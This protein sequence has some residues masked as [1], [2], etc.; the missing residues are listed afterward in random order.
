MIKY[1]RIATNIC[2]FFVL[3][4]F[5]SKISLSF[6]ALVPYQ[7]SFL[8]FQHGMHPYTNLFIHACLSPIVL[9]YLIKFKSK[10]FL[11]TEYKI[12][13][14]VLIF[15][16]TFQTFFQIAF[17]NTDQSPFYQLSG[18]FMAIGLIGIY[19][20]FIPLFLEKKIFINLIR[21]ASL[22]IIIISFLLLFF[23]FQT[24]KGGRFTGVFKHIP[25]MVSVSVL[26]YIFYFPNLIKMDKK[27]I[28][29]LILFILLSLTI[30]LTATKTSF[31]AMILTI[32]LGIFIFPIT[33]KNQFLFKSAFFLSI[34]FLIIFLHE[35]IT[36]TILDVSTG[37]TELG[38]RK[39]QNGV[40]SRVEE[41]ERGYDLFQRSP[42]FGLGLLYK[43]FKN[44]HDDVEVD[45]YNSFKDPHNIF[46][47][48]A[49]IGGIPLL[50][51]AVYAVIAMIL[52]SFKGLR[53]DC[54]HTRL[55]ALYLI[56]H[57]P[58]LIIYHAHF[59]L[60][61]IADRFYWLIFGYLGV[62]KKIS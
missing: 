58:I 17:V 26:A 62:S 60:G 24:F 40:Q 1:N 53:S 61:G 13:I 9:F 23:G 19:G 48:S 14:L 30:F 5:F 39:A 37:K 11:K 25:H 28:S 32:F 43:Y 20:V 35:P 29:K 46:A 47:S 3:L 33:F 56:C 22:L 18:L 12:L 41:V 7:Y 55:F 10:N 49:V 15:I 59:S 31:I 36:Q 50:V 44:G 16:L 2:C 38:Y 45:Q 52:A 54:P 6:I 51:F 8:I 57:I 27:I 21:R 34:F 42:I 4:I